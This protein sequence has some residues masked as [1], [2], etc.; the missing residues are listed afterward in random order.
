MSQN[1]SE[2]GE[3]I[4]KSF[5]DKLY[6]KYDL[7]LTNRIVLDWGCSWG[8][9]IK[10]LHDKFKVFMLVGN[11]IYDYWKI[12]EY[13]HKWVYDKFSNIKFFTGNLSNINIPVE[14]KFDYIFCT[15]VLQYMNPEQMTKNL[16]R[17]YSLLRP[18]GELIGYFNTYN[19]TENTLDNF[20][21][22]K[23]IIS[24][25]KKFRVVN[26]LTTSSY[27]AV[28]AK[29]GFEILDHYLQDS[30]EDG[31]L[32]ENLFSAK[33]ISLLMAKGD[34]SYAKVYFRLIRPIEAYELEN[35]SQIARTVNWNPE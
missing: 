34:L 7:D 30:I 9:L 35:I 26:Y 22:D 11:D 3:E 27:F 33:E 31:N 20:I 25:F 24:M 6:D 16:H 4:A 17:A 29:I 19:S 2:Y 5:W 1:I 32:T 10:Y 18:G 21:K 15:D 14:Y 28:F 12:L 23:E 8:Y 13:E